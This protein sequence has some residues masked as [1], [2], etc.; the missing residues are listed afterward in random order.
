MLHWKL[1]VRLSAL[2]ACFVPKSAYAV[3][4]AALS[5]FINFIVHFIPCRVITCIALW[6]QVAT[7]VTVTVV[8]H[9]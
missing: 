2:Y 4:E 3:D 6:Q 5:H 9:K 7:T 1:A 8:Y